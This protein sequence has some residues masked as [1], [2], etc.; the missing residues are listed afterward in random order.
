MPR[1]SEPSPVAA[2]L[3]ATPAELEAARQDL[4]NAEALMQSALQRI[5]A[6]PRA[7]KVTMTDALRSAFEHLLRMKAVLEEVD[8]QLHRAEPTEE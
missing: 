2:E 7:H 1:S 4:A 3:V 5:K 8:A 6:V